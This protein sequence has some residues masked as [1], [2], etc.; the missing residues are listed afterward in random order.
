M[1]CQPKLERFY[2]AAQHDPRC[3]KTLLSRF[4]SHHQ[5]LGED[6]QPPLTDNNV[7]R[8]AFLFCFGFCSLQSWNPK[9]RLFKRNARD[10]ALN[11]TRIMNAQ[12]GPFQAGT[13]DECIFNLA[14]LPAIESLHEIAA[15]NMG[16]PMSPKQALENRTLRSSFAPDTVD[17]N[18]DYVWSGS[19]IMTSNW[20][21]CMM[22]AYQ[23][24]VM[25]VPPSTV[26]AHSTPISQVQPSKLA[27]MRG[28]YDSLVFDYGRGGLKALNAITYQI[29]NELYLI[30][31][32]EKPD[33]LR[34]TGLQ[35]MLAEWDRKGLLDVKES[36]TA[37]DQV[38]LDGIEG[39]R[40]GEMDKLALAESHKNAF[41]RDR[42]LQPSDGGSRASGAGNCGKKA[43]KGKQ[44]AT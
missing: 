23:G 11:W 41:D 7:I 28:I 42:A 40:R 15:A 44:R 6:F 31:T 36:N 14:D 30:M 33:D 16:L 37:L 25:P 39:L 3:R 19:P 13:E 12:E 32:D 17:G 38:I 8:A 34:F 43:A 4:A 9:I 21:R 22:Q 10:F 29:L 2:E 26:R 20:R 24:R 1:P 18:T 27:K 5:T 35:G